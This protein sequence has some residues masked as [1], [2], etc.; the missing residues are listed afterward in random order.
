MSEKW[1]PELK[2]EDQSKQICGQ[3]QDK[4]TQEILPQHNELSIFD[5]SFGGGGGGG[6]VFLA[7]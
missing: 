5:R 1:D 6:N 3:V 2:T 4:A 7:K